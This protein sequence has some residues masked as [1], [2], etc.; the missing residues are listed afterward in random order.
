MENSEPPVA[1]KAAE[2]FCF[3]GIV[4][5]ARIG[6]FVVIVICILLDSVTWRAM[7]VRQRSCTD[8]VISIV[9]IR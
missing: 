7:M 2:V 6:L 5:L 3:Q 8:C 9:S 4:C 1:A